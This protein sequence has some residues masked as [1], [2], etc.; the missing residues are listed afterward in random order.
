V[1][2]FPLE[3]QMSRFAC[4]GFFLLCS[5]PGC[6]CKAAHEFSNAEKYNEGTEWLPV[7][8]FEWSETYRDRLTPLLFP[9]ALC[10]PRSWAFGGSFSPPC[11]KSCTGMASPRR[12]PRGGTRRQPTQ[13]RRGLVRTASSPILPPSGAPPPQYVPRTLPHPARKRVFQEQEV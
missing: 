4:W 7:G 12:Y 9:I 10:S 2:A 11:S 3:W 6:I 13:E 1:T 8:S 5:H